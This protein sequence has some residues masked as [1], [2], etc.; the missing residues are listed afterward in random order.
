MKS[1]KMTRGR[2]RY[3]DEKHQTK[4]REELQYEPDLEHAQ[5]QDAQDNRQFDGHAPKAEKFAA[6][7][8]ILLINLEF[9]S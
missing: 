6:L 7:P 1:R 9:P 4:Q 5:A 2:L 8:L 3:R